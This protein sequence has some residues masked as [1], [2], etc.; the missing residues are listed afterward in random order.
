[1][2]SVVVPTLQ[3]EKLLEQTL[4]VFDRDWRRR[5]HAELIISDGGSTDGTLAIAE[6]HADSITV[7][8]GPER[9]TIAGGRNAGAQ[10]ARGAVIVFINGDTVPADIEQFTNCIVDFAQRTGPYARASALACPVRFRE[11]EERLPDILFHVFYNRYV[12]LLSILRIGAGRG[13]CQVVR[14]EVFERVGGYRPE[15]VAGEDF[16]LFARIGV[17]ARVRFAPELLVY[18]SPRRFRKFG[19]FRVLFSWTIN[20]LSVLLRGRSS[21]DKWEPVR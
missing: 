2:I 12:H 19:Y 13:E 14:R 17:R 21:S 9:Q 6:Q 8:K 7:H 1:M 16:D 15:L 20:A 11:G 5:V 10:T 3:E 4:S 18:E